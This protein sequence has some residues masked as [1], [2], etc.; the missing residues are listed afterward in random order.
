M[1]TVFDDLPGVRIHSYM[2][3]KK[4]SFLYSIGYPKNKSTI[5]YAKESCS[6][7]YCPLNYDP[8]KA[9]KALETLGNLY[10]FHVWGKWWVV[11]N[12]KIF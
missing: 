4:L 11:D 9:L 6:L 2:L 10:G 12:K 5:S 8:D 3:R 1:F 7:Q